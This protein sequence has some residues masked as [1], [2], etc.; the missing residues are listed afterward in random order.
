MTKALVWIRS[1]V[2][3]ASPMFF[4]WA[5]IAFLIATPIFSLTINI[6]VAFNSSWVYSTGFDRNNIEQRTGVPDEELN[7]IADEFIAYFGSDDE[8]LNVQLYGR[9]LFNTREVIHMKDVKALVQGMYILSYLAGLVI[10]GYLAWGFQRTGRQFLRP[11][12]RR[13]KR[14][15][16]FTIGSLAIIGSVIGVGFPFFFT[17]FH[18]IAFR[19]DFWMLDPRRDFLVVMFPEQFWLE[20]T[21][22]AAF[23]TVAQ[24]MLAAG[25]SWLVLRRLQA[26]DAVEGSTSLANDGA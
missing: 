12:L 24:A 16:L 10:V 4:R 13:V 6:R 14:A 15:G 22:M 2:A 5:G 9:D 7:R 26:S 23:A 8:F 21:L 3:I 1:R 18:E 17:L 11:A 25:G 19:N 20:A